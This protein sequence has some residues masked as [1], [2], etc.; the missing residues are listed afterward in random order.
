MLV[1]ASIAHRNAISQ[2][3]SVQPKMM[4]TTVIVWRLGTSR[5][6]A[7]RVGKKT[8]RQQA[9]LNL[10]DAYACASAAIVANM[11]ASDAEEGISA[12]FEKRKPNWA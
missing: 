2:P 6:Y 9:G 1:S 8:V 12:F 11:L 10:A 3:I 7:I 4:L 5:A